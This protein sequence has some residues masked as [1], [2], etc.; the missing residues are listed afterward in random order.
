MRASE[1]LRP[2]SARKAFLYVRVCSTELHIEGVEYEKPGTVN[3]CRSC[4]HVSSQASVGFVCIDCKSRHDSEAIATRDF[5]K[6]ELTRKGERA[7]ISNEPWV[8]R[9]KPTIGTSPQEAVIRQAL[10]LHSRYGRPLAILRVYFGTENCACTTDRLPSDTQAS[11]Q[12]AAILHSETPG[13]RCD[14][15][16]RKWLSRLHA[17]NARRW[18]QFLENPAPG[19]YQRHL[20]RRFRCPY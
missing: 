8:T 4:G 16:D 18:S 7:L 6:Y 1:R 11:T 3:T 10:R 19:S 13:Y 9:E 14:C 17:G 5:Y 20:A 15:R 12:L 2:T